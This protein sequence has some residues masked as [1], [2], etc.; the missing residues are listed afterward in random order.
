MPVFAYYDFND[1][2]N[3]L[4]D[5][6]LDNG[7]Q[8]G[9]YMGGAAASEG[10]LQLDG[11]TAYAKIYPAEMFQDGR[12]TVALEFSMTSHSGEGPDTV[13]SRDS[14]E[15]GS[16]FRVDVMP[17]G[18]IRVS[19]DSPD[20][21]TV[22]TT[23][24][25]FINPNDQIDLSYSWNYGGETPGQ[26]VIN[27]LTTGATHLDDVPNTLTME[28]PSPEVQWKVGTSAAS[29]EA[30]TL[31][32]LQDF[33]NGSVGYLSFS[34]SVDNIVE[35][36]DPDARDDSADTA[37]DRSVIIPVLSNDV[38]PD[39][40]SLTVTSATADVGDVVINPDGTL[41]YTPP[42]GYLGDVAISYTISDGRGG[43][44]TATVTVNVS[45]GGNTGGL[46]DGIVWGT[47]AGDVID[48][49]YTGDND[50]DF[51]DR[52]DA[53]LSGHVHDDDYIIA[54]AG[55][56]TVYAGQGA[57]IVFGG[58]G[59]D[60]VY[61]GAGNDTLLGE[62]GQDSL[63]GGD[64]DDLLDG[65]A[66]DDVLYGDAGDDTLLGGDGYDL[67]DG[68]SGDDLLVGGAG[69]DTLRGGE[70]AD[71]LLGG[72][73]RDLILGAN[74]GDLID[75]GSGGDD[76]DTLDLTGMGPLR[77]WRD[78]ENIENGYITFFD[79]EGNE[80]GRSHFF[81]I[82]KIIPCF[83]PG[84]LIATPKGPVPVQ[85][86]QVGDRVMTRDNGIQE[87]RWTGARHLSAA[88]L[89]MAS[90]LQPVMIRRGA[91]GNGLPER[92]MMVSPNHRVLVANDRTALY[93]DE[94]EVLV[95]AK[96]LVGI[97]GIT[98]IISSG[99][100]YLHFMCDRHE[101][102]LSDGA[103]TET[104]QPGDQ[105]LQGMGNAQR[106]E[107]FEIFPELQESRGIDSYVAARKTLKKHEALL[108][109]R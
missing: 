82:E 64:G 11:N 95:A 22:F 10:R 66:K 46:R 102:V 14:R 37:V 13:L 17:D 65:G 47:G 15:E 61:G 77:V 86:L 48:A 50:G 54:G 38:D 29:T 9:M 91:L 8:Q 56:D 90:H 6:A 59:A 5:G 101:V 27:N 72:D 31:W 80:T 58:T 92:D 1:P 60:S 16:G 57:D 84:T 96:H 4:R 98:P 3:I 18:A 76:W 49:A 99:T 103:W 108:L 30:G 89:A 33:F 7:A 94:H 93:F 63:Y 34:D 75:G 52:G 26:L 73:D 79:A 83:T 100:S 32:P 81:D 53:L 45:N 2:D 105:T 104:F 68:G 87:I 109:R 35:N 42:E 36:E 44:D 24:A 69:A 85:D 70:G 62:G 97:E 78:P 12:G 107:I 25:G 20:G 51:V 71:T 23:E 41:T 67:L 21:P 39:G 88:E 19:H 28:M 106:N 40:D 43:S 74:P 55:N